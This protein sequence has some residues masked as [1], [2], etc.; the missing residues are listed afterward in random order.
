MDLASAKRSAEKMVRFILSRRL[1]N[2][3]GLN[4]S[5]GKCVMS[6]WYDMNNHGKNVIGM[7]DVTCA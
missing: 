2:F 6:E 1:L 7:H 4:G 3:I 5:T